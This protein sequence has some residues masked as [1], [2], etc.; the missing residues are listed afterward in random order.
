MHIYMH[1]Y[2]LVCMF[3]YILRVTYDSAIKI[4][5]LMICVSI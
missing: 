2:M 5:D 4:N 1:I 3:V